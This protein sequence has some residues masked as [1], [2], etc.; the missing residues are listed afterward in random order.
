VEPMAKTSLQWHLFALPVGLKAAVFRETTEGLD[1]PLP[2]PGEN[3]LILT[4]INYKGD[5]RI[6]RG[7][8]PEDA[9]QSASPG[10]SLLGRTGSP[11]IFRSAAAIQ[12]A[13]LAVFIPANWANLFF[14]GNAQYHKI[15]QLLEE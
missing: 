11:M 15:E 10:L 5:L 1:L 9:E 4:F 8:R 3:G 7:S 14:D 13:A 6:K 12:F 2:D